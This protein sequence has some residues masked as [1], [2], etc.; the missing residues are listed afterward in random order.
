MAELPKRFLHFSSDPAQV[1]KS[2][3]PKANRNLNG[4]KTAVIYRAGVFVR[5]VED[6]R[7][8]SIYDYNFKAGE[9]QIDECRNASDYTVKAAVARLYR[10]ASTAELVPVFLALVEH[11]PAFEAG[12]DQDYILPAWESPKEEQKVN[13]QHAWKAVAADAVLCGPSNTIA[14]FVEK[15][16]YEAKTIQ[17]SNLVFAAARF[18]IKTDSQVL[19]ENEKNGKEITPPTVAAQTAVDTVWSWLVKYNMTNDKAKPTVGCFRDAMNAGTRILGFCDDTGVYLA[20]DQASGGV[21]SKACL[22]TALEEVLHWV[23]KAGDN[24]KDLQ[25]FAFCLIVEIL[26]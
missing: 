2:F 24:S 21:P 9:L 22:K 8:D 7:D 12:L 4:K 19:S 5:E 15:K 20:D 10:K 17:S 16:G 25:N 6:Y 18:G 26:A 11:Q 23:T 1:T 13:W 14:E 3:L